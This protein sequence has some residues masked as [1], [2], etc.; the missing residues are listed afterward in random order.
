[1]SRSYKKTPWT[2]DKKGKSKKRC[3]NSKIRMFLK[4]PNHKLQNNSYKKVYDSYD[5]CDYGWLETWE[6]YKKELETRNYLYP[7]EE[8]INWK[9]EYQYWYKTYKMK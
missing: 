4:N 6:Q 2:G 7:S 5:I 8:K 9:K 3:A 1:M